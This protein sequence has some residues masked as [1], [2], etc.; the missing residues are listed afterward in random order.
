MDWKF[1]FSIIS[2]YIIPLSLYLFI[3]FLKICFISTFIFI[4]ASYLLYI[5]SKAYFEVLLH[6]LIYKHLDFNYK[7]KLKY[8][9]YKILTSS[10]YILTHFVFS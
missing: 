6:L 8:N 5:Y 7:M 4:A 2:I 3:Y 10:F 9:P 1:P